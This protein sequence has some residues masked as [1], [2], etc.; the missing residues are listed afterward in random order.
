MR[1]TPFRDLVIAIWTVVVCSCSIGCWRRVECATCSRISKA[2]PATYLGWK[3]PVAASSVAK[4]VRA[5][6]VDVL[7]VD[8][9]DVVPSARICKDLGS[10]GL[11]NVELIMAVEEE[12]KLEIPDADAEC[13]QTVG[14]LTNYLHHHQN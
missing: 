9:K 6:V 11:K 10:D 7:Q 2:T 1:R 5:L 4:R 8:E 14:D 13:L 12:F 3:G